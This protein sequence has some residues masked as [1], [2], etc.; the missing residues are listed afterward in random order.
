MR[1]RTIAILLALAAL[2]PHARPASAKIPNAALSFVTRPMIAC[3]AG[4]VVFTTIMRDVMNNPLPLEDVMV[5]FE[6]CPSVRLPLVLGD[7]GYTV[8]FGPGQPPA[9]A[10]QAYADFNGE[11]DFAIRAGGTCPA[12][13]V[14]IY[15]DGVL[16]ALRSLASPDQD[17]DLTVGPADEALRPPSSAPAIPPPTSTATA[18]DGSR[19]QISAPISAI[20]RRMVTPVASHLGDAPAAYCSHATRCPSRRRGGPRVQEHR[21]SK[22]SLGVGSRR[23][24][25]NSTGPSDDPAHSPRSAVKGGSP[26]GHPARSPG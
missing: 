15:G 7:E 21:G 10:L 25:G 9:V 24:R 5:S 8:V 14:K 26:C 4:E 16:V 3:P 19:P 11:K 6:D 18:R 20:T 23:S 2:V 12:S 13:T 17:G 1:S 22:G